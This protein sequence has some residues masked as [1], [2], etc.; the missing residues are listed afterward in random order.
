MSCSVNGIRHIAS[1]KSGKVNC[2]KCQIQYDNRSNK[3][4]LV[5]SVKQRHGIGQSSRGDDH[6]ISGVMILTEVER[7]PVGVAFVKMY[8]LLYQTLTNRE[9]T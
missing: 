1:G 2:G 7:N 6:R 5:S 3:T 8:T 9:T 4:C